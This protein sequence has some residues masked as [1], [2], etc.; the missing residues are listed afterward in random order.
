MDEREVT[1]IHNPVENA[2]PVRTIKRVYCYLRVSVD[3]QEMSMESQMEG[4]NQKIAANQDWRL[5]GVYADEGISGTRARKRPQFLKMIKDAQAGGCEI[6]LCKSLSRFA[7]NTLDALTYVRALKEH[8]VAC[9]FI[10]EGLNTANEASEMILAVLSA[11]AQEESFSISENVK[12]GLR[13]RYEMGEIRWTQ[14]YGYRNAG[15]EE[16]N[17]VIHE[18]EAQVVRMVFNFY[19]TGMSVPAIVDQLNMAG[20]PAPRGGKW[21]P[22]TVQNMLR[23]E[24]YAGDTVLQKYICL[25]HITHKCVPNDATEVPSYYVRNSHI[26]IV[27][28]RTFDQ[29]Q[30]IMELKAPHGESS[31]YPYEDTKLVCPFC[32]EKLVTRLVHCNGKRKTL[33]CFGEQGC[34]GF[35]VKTWMVDAVLLAAF[36]E[37]DEVHG[38]G[39]GSK[40]IREL[41]GK[42]TPE[43]VEY[44]FL[45]DAVKSITFEGT[46]ETTQKGGGVARRW[47]MTVNWQSG[48]STTLPL[49][50]SKT[51]E[52][53]QVAELYDR[54]LGRIESGEYVPARPKDRRERL[55]AEAT[56][57][58]PIS[59]ASANPSEPSSEPANG[60]EEGKRAE[61]EN[62]QNRK[63]GEQA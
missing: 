40:R 25:S 31:R 53:V 63:E 16:L 33:G 22:M 51:E 59:R 38:T 44:A 42:G 20:V 9:I 61:Q 17:V 29:V 57:I 8:G 62:E 45:A 32:G 50:E 13:K 60:S 24:R 19:R 7:R 28:R 55:A 46:E 11:F 2:G 52:P 39:D 49:P 36:E 48:D 21:T 34:H 14:L 47:D 26:P 58:R 15:E 10:K 1:R 18:A 54:Y 23:N 5:E 41:K 3:T 30:R 27:D 35:A 6:I 12:W 56:T 43:T 4:F 37:L